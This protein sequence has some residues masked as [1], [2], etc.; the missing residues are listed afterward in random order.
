MKK[1][2]LFLRK[3]ICLICLFASCSVIAQTWPPAGMQGDG[4]NENPWEIT[5]PEHLAA[6]ANYVNAGNG[7][8]T[9]G[10]YYKL[11]N[12]I[13]LS[14][15]NN[16]KP[17]GERTNSFYATCFN[18]H[19]NGNNKTVK[20]LTIR[21]STENYIGLF[22]LMY[23]GSI[24][25]LVVEECDVVGGESNVGGLVG[26]NS[27]SINNCNVTGKIKGKRS[28]IGGL[29]GINHGSII[30]C[31]TVCDV[32]G[33]QS[34]FGHIGGLIGM[35]YGNIS[36][37][38][39]T[40]NID[41][42]GGRSGGLIG[43]NIGYL[44]NCHATGTVNGNFDAGGLIGYNQGNIFQ[45][46]ATGNVNGIDEIGGLVG[47][48]FYADISN[49][50]AAG[51]VSG[52]NGVGGLVGNNWIAAISNSYAT[53][54]VNATGYLGDIGGL[55]GMNSA[56]PISCCHAIGNVV[57]YGFSVGGLVG[58]NNGSCT[59]SNCYATGDVNQT[60]NLRN[61]VGG[62]VGDNCNSTIFNCYA[63]GNV[64]G[65]EENAGGLIGRNS[66][67]SII[68]YCYAIGSVSGSY[69]VGGLVG[70]NYWDNP[71]INNCIAANASVVATTNTINVNRIAG[72]ADYGVCNNNYAL[73]TMI[74]RSNGLP[75][76]II[77]GS[78]QAGISKV[79]DT[80]QNFAFYDLANNWG[81]NAWDID[82]ETNPNKIWKICD[83][84]SLPFFQ[85]QERDCGSSFTIIATAGYNGIINPYGEISVVESTDRNFAFFADAGYKVESLLIDG[86]N[87][88]EFIASGN[89]TFK[90]ITE[91]HTIHVT[92][93]PYVNIIENKK[94]S[95]I[96]VYP[97]PTNGE[98]RI[99][100]YELQ[101]TNVE[102]FDIYGRK[103]QMA[104]ISFNSPV[105]VIDI[106]RLTA[107]VYFLKI[108]TEVGQVIKKVLRE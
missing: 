13:D 42:Q 33:G 53:G 16:W 99:T 64:N 52:A 27:A 17:I 7:E 24:E 43:E 106:S 92:F 79:I 108:S 70:V 107:G 10:R 84:L 11:M 98:L 102:F 48:N 15:Y 19:L 90:D 8:N 41:T 73:N 38:H 3:I 88:S 57:G 4:T 96:I 29:I 72:N 59:I 18:G 47:Y 45:C 32:S 12:D 81:N 78:P 40:G 77:D 66:R 62:L 94:T 87:K 100:N 67:S 105:T 58:F 28:C 50:Y 6:L 2:K 85:W 104:T 46:F 22:A 23:V 31:Y 103:I 34:P 37:C 91:N 1:V 44:S 74:V 56:S 26:Y 51:D 21:R 54:D 97:N 63:S 60:G 68:S 86:V 9:I 35:N 20:N 75:V 101:I 39:A 5:M 76:T 65:K 55:V 14:K 89:Y 36:N 80:L 93:T 95:D 49:C 61:C 82:T 83:A 30:N 69:N 25:N 71:T